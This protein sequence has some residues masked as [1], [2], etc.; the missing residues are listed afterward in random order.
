[1]YRGERLNSITHL[2]GAALSVAGLVFLL[3]IGR[4]HD[5]WQVTSFAIYGSTLILLYTIST[6]YHSFRG[7]AKNVF[8]KFD[9]LA[10]YLLI[11]GSYT[12]FALI[13]LRGP[14][15]WTLF[16]LSWGLALV[17]ILQELW[18][19]HRT[20]FFS[21]L[22]YVVMGWLVLIAGRQLVESLPTGGIAWL[23]GGGLIYTAGIYFFLNDERLPHGHGIWHLF[24][25]GGSAA[26]Y[27]CV[28]NYLT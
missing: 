11:A 25:L 9:Y 22:I 24:V 7:R 16:G 14:W 27:W 10:I 4:P 18:I 23:A 8:R 2:L 17:G 21:L 15:G 12:P 28:L 3:V 19:G 26:Q 20:R 6:L 13:T 5:A 1:M